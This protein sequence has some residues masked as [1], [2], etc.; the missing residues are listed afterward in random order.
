MKTGGIAPTDLEVLR[1]ARP[2]VRSVLA[3]LIYLRNGE[4]LNGL[5]ASYCKADEFLGVLHDD[6]EKA[7]SHAAR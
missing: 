6:V 4:K 1:Q 2:Y 7:E 3:F 5:A